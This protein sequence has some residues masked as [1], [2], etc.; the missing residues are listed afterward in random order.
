[1]KTIGIM[2]HDT[3]NKSESLGILEQAAKKQKAKTLYI[4]PKS[5]DYTIK[6]K[7]SA[8]KEI[9][10]LYPRLYAETNF[11]EFLLSLAGIEYYSNLG[12]P[13]INSLDGLIIGAD[14]F[15]QYQV[16]AKSGINIPFTSL[17][18]AQEMIKP[19]LRQFNYPIVVKRQF[20]YGGSGVA[21]LESERSARSVIGSTLKDGHP[22]I[23]QE[24][25]KIKDFLDFRVYVVG[26]HAIYGII[27]TAPSGDFRAN[28]AQGGKLKFFMPDREIS[29]LAVKVAQIVKLDIC[30]VDFLKYNNQYY[31][32][33]LNRSM[34][35]QPYSGGHKI[36]ADEIIRYCLKKATR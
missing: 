15:R 21:I 4:N 20:G 33:E 10:I 32:V 16:V 13:M 6:N 19:V 27:R 36:V 35:V 12:I 5:I 34:S 25:L 29:N 28:V 14:K 24:Y 18:G 22:L 9:D 1:M 23:I 8:K 17:I 30:A 3:P 7:N 26:D 31:M 2:T 11:E